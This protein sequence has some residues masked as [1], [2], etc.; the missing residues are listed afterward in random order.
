LLS[1]FLQ[2]SPA[3]KCDRIYRRCGNDLHTCLMQIGSGDPA[4]LGFN[5]CMQTTADKK[6]K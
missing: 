6:T 2:S 4:V 5:T 3:L 1:N